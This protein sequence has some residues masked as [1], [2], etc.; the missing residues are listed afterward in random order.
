MTD[1]VSKFQRELCEI[2]SEKVLEEFIPALQSGRHLY[3]LID[4]HTHDSDFFEDHILD[5]IDSHLGIPYKVDFAKI[6]RGRTFVQTL[7]PLIF[8]KTQFPFNLLKNTRHGKSIRILKMWAE[9]ASGSLSR[10]CQKFLECRE[11]SDSEKSKLGLD[12]DLS[13]DED[14][15]EFFRECVESHSRF[16]SRNAV[17]LFKNMRFN[18]KMM[19]LPSTLRFLEK[20]ESE[21]PTAF[22][23]IVPRQVE[24]FLMSLWNRF[25]H[26]LLLKI[27]S[28]DIQGIV[29]KI[30]R[31]PGTRGKLKFSREG[32]QLFC[33]R[34]FSL[35]GKGIPA[36][37][38][39]TAL[40]DAIGY[41]ELHQIDMIDA[42]DISDLFSTIQVKIGV[43]VP[44]PP[45]ECKSPYFGPELER[46]TRE[47]KRR[48][49]DPHYVL[50]YP[51]RYVLWNME[52][53]YIL[54]EKGKDEFNCRKRLRY[55]HFR[56][57]SRSLYKLGYKYRHGT[58]SW[59]FSP[60]S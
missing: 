36:S 19:D 26:V 59:L 6:G 48:E 20:V 4:T 1:Y 42:G 12:H 38:I 33:R 35:F 32:I 50:P 11:C 45:T 3:F 23:M 60:S 37:A 31:K 28:D 14:A 47:C 39:I 54:Y 5:A 55:G 40:N 16:N 24:Y 27:N 34:M 15:I 56:K 57:I 9:E 49:L 7:L 25:A 2:L 52:N 58:G 10:T 21:L 30:C 8:L 41:A 51:F 22:V 18:K 17:F 44:R 13:N 53:G 43:P 29:E 46:L